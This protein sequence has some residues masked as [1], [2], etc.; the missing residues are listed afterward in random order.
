[1]EFLSLKDGA[2][3]RF[4]YALI[5]NP[6]HV[7]RRQFEKGKVPDRF[8]NAL[9]MCAAEIG[10]PDLEEDMP[11]LSTIWKKVKKWYEVVIQ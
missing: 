3:N 9:I 11:D 5:W 8:W 10:A 1:M 6:Y 4:G 7:I 2:S